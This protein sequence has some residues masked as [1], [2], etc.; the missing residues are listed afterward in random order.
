M[1]LKRLTRPFKVKSLS[2]EGEFE[3][4]GSVF[5]VKDSYGDVV[6]KGAFGKSLDDWKERGTLPSMLW[7]H[8]A[9]EPV[10][11][12][13]EMKEDDHGLYV[14][15]KILTEAGD[16]ERRAH[17]HV[18]AGS[19]R[20]LSIGYSIPIGGIEFDKDNDAYLLKQINLWEVSLVTFP[21]NP[22]AEIDTV[23]A[24]LEAGPKEIERILRD[25]GFSRS[26][27]KALLA[28]GLKGLRDAA[29]EPANEAQNNNLFAA[30]TRLRSTT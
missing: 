14:R 15:G 2:D 23:K 4:Y 27:A 30:L 24:A 1:K 7:Q 25:A 10:G 16:L 21:A 5:G 28:D 12:Y 29:T 13:A 18:K 26:Q 3:G 19:V 9:H 22:E 17:A 6:V 8:D 20:G 11:V